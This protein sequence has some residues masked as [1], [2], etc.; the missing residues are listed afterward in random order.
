LAFGRQKNGGQSR[1]HRGFNP[2]FP[3]DEERQIR[4]HYLAVGVLLTVRQAGDLSV[5]VLEQR[6]ARSKAYIGG[7]LTIIFGYVFMMGFKWLAEHGYLMAPLAAWCPNIILLLL[8]GFLVYQKNRL[9][10]SEGTT[11]WRNLPFKKRLFK[12]E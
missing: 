5:H 9:P 2:G 11:D 10:P 7:I 12:P 4:A 8:G 6:R 1:N 3:G